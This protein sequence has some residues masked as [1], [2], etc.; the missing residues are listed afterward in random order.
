[1][2]FRKAESAGIPAGAAGDADDA[3]V[4]GQSVEYGFG[5]L[6]VFELGVSTIWSQL[7]DDQSTLLWFM[8]VTN[9]SNNIVEYAFLENDL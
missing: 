7:S 3:V 1:V 6:P 8:V 5:W 9:N 2:V 4:Y